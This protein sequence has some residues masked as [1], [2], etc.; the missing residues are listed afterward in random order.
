MTCDEARNAAWMAEDGEPVPE[1]AE[2][3]LASCAA[4]RDALNDRRLVI[5]AYRALGEPA[6]GVAAGGGV[7]RAARRFRRR[8]WAWGAAAAVAAAALLAAL[9]SPDRAGPV[10]PGPAAAGTS[11]P[12]YAFEVPRASVEGRLS[13]LEW[14]W[15]PGTPAAPAAGATDDRWGIGDLRKRI[16][17]LERSLEASSPARKDPGQGA[18]PP[19][20]ADRTC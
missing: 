18:I 9:L 16:E 11:L 7:F 1:D 20:P 3:H 10:A 12:D 8:A 14:E 15:S 4:C 6:P 17:S 2:R 19:G 13:Y 5:A